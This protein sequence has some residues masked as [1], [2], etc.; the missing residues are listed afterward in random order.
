MLL[1]RRKRS[2]ERVNG[3]LDLARKR[4]VASRIFFGSTGW[5]GNVTILMLL[6]CAFVL[7]PY[8]SSQ[9][10]LCY[11]KVLSFVG[12]LTSLSLY[13]VYVGSG[14][15]M[16]ISFFSSIMRGVGAG[17]CIFE[18]KGR[19]PIIANGTGKPL[20]PSHRGLINFKNITSEYPTRK[21]VGILKDFRLEIGVG[22]SVDLCKPSVQILFL[23]YAERPW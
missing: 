13:T 16:L 15:Q 18:I 22:E 4:A 9:V 3:V 2:Y 14:L 5:N 19:H 1:R 7:S 11:P 17:T 6:G 20:D 12:D 8:R 21:G 10:V 23:N